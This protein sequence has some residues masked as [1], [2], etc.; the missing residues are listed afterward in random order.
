MPMKGLRE[1]NGAKFRTVL[2]W[3]ILFFLALASIFIYFG[4]NV[5]S[6][7]NYLTVTIFDVGQGDAALIETPGGIQILIDGGPDNTI[8]RKL[9]EQLGFFDRSLDLVIGTHPDR[10][11]IAGLNDVFKRYQVGTVLTTE[12]TGQSAAATA[13][14]KALKELDAEIIYARSGLVYQL[15]NDAILKILFPE[16]NPADLESNTASIILS[17]CSTVRL[18]LCLPVTRPKA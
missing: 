9:S 7:A 11:H 8:T 10:D 18:A 3:S 6:P 15:D 2:W 5:S 17:N 12:K 14:E 1:L 4:F 16:Q 13:Y